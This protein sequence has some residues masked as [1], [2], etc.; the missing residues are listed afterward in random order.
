MFLNLLILLACTYVCNGTYVYEQSIFY[1]LV[2][3]EILFEESQGIACEYSGEY[4][5]LGMHYI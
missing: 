4:I 1:R 5:H 2:S 3:D